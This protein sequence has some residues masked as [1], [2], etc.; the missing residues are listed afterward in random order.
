LAN[1]TNNTAT[2]TGTGLNLSLT[3]S[4]TGTD[5]LISPGAGVT[6]GAAMQISASGT[7]AIANGLL[8]IDHSG[9]YP[10]TGGLLNV[11][12]AASTAGTLVDFTNNTASYT[13]TIF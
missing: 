9:A 3:G 7:S 4:T 8:Q 1:F 13:G 10:S 12:S 2:F 6:S 5:L 11:N